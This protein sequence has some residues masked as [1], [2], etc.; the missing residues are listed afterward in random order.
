MTR[1]GLLKSAVTFFAIAAMTLVLVETYLRVTGFEPFSTP[2]DQPQRYVPEP[3][4][5]WVKKP[6]TYRV[7][8]GSEVPPRDV[9]TRFLTNSLRATAKDMTAP[10]GSRPQLLLLGCS[11]TEGDGISDHETFAWKLQERFP[12]IEVLNMGTSAWSTYQNLIALENIALRDPKMASIR[13]VIYGLVDFHDFRNIGNAHWH[14]AL[15]SQSSTGTVDLPSC[16]LDEAR[17]LRCGSPEPYLQLPLRRVLAFSTLAEELIVSLQRRHR[18]ELRREIEVKLLEAMSA[19]LA[20][21]GIPFR[22]VYLA[23]VKE[24]K[25]LYLELLRSRG[26]DVD[27]CVHPEQSPG[28]SM[29]DKYVVRANGHPNGL[30]ND[31]WAECLTP[32]VATMMRATVRGRPDGSEPVV[33]PF[34][35]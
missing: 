29:D 19:R 18:D 9:E 3:T 31:Y 14:R 8:L 23:A 34:A 20:D 6:G 2:P 33:A 16:D 13:A 27:D 30:V 17:N 26:L 15:A 4:I 10:S 32:S 7:H 28:Q 21:R 12:D 24:P 22:V 35:G 5:G 25:E 11:F 1:L